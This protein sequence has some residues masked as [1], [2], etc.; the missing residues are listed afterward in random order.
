MG[1]RSFNDKAVMDVVVLN[2]GANRL[3]DDLA[4]DDFASTPRSQPRRRLRRLTLTNYPKPVERSFGPSQPP[5]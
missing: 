5:P 4:P 3:V 2:F 1:L